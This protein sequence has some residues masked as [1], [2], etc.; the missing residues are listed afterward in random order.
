[1]DYQHVFVIRIS[2]GKH[3]LC[4]ANS[5]QQNRQGPESDRTYISLSEQLLNK[6]EGTIAHS[7]KS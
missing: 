2:Y 6:V 4:W 7:L 3:R 1:M 5:C